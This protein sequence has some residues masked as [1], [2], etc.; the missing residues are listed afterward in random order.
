MK[1]TSF[2]ALSLCAAFALTSCKSQE[3]AYKK[4]YEKAQAEAAQQVE[5]DKT[6]VAVEEKEEAVDVTPLQ[7]AAP[8]E[9]ENV[10]VRS[11]PGGMEVI[12]GNELKSYSVV[13]GSFTV[14]ANAEGL[15][16]TLD[17]AGYDARVIKT[18]ET[19]NG[20]TGWYRVAASSYDS[21]SSAAQSRKELLSKYKD[22]W[23]LYK[24]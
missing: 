17:N 24:K 11:I 15:K 5:T 19:I 12:S 16:K 9:E 22:A 14:Q 18:N 21:K 10:A 1:K 8:A 2:L 20:H 4:A 6:V 13:V 23:L 7:P 3:S